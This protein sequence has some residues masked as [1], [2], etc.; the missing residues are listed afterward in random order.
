MFLPCLENCIRINWLY[1]AVDW[2]FP[3]LGIVYINYLGKGP[4]M[5]KALIALMIM[6]LLVACESSATNDAASEYEADNAL[7]TNHLKENGFSVRHLEFT[8]DRVMI[9]DAGWDRAELL[10][11]IKTREQYSTNYLVS[12]SN[13]SNITVSLRGLTSEWADIARFAM[14]EWNAIPGSNLRFV[15]TSKKRGNITMKMGN[16]GTQGTLASASFPNR[17]GK[18]GNSITV[19]TVN[20]GL[21]LSEKRFTMVHEMGHCIGFRHTNW[22]DRNSDGNA[23]TNDNEGVSSYGANHIPG[24]PTGLDPNSVMNAIVD[25]WSGFGNYDKVATAYLY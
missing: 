14:A 23:T 15:E 25:A 22:F 11:D 6:F 19:N 16:L 9:Q 1:I 21:S 4:K 24:T 20:Y 3:K 13:A 17:R 8:N 10:A 7:I 5:K 18:P 12:A 2:E